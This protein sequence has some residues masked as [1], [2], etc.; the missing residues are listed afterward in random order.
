MIYSLYKDPII[1]KKISS[2]LEYIINS[3]LKSID[4][5]VSIILTGFGRGEGSVIIK[6]QNVNVLNDCDLL[7]CT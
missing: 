7:C 2:D 6:D 5:V 1:N 3:I 4:G